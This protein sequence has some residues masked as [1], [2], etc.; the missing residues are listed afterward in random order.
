MTACLS[1]TSKLSQPSPLFEVMKGQSPQVLPGDQ[2]FALSYG[3]WHLSKLG[4][5]NSVGNS[6]G[7]SKY[8]TKDSRTT[9]SFSG[10]AMSDLKRKRSKSSTV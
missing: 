10:A 1:V 3:T 4:V 5:N 2:A 9:A 8:E 7:N 6:V